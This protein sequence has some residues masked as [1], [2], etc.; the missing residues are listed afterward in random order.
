[1]KILVLGATGQVGRALT[2]ILGTSAIGLTRHHAD[3]S[4]PDSLPA[5]LAKT[6]ASNRIS[7]VI[8]AAAY[9]AVDLAETHEPE[10]M[11][12]NADSPGVIAGFCAAHN[13]PFVHYSTDYVFSGE[14]DR[15]WTERDPTAP[16]SAYGR[17]KL[18]GE[19]QVARAG[20]NHLILRTS[21]VYDAVGKNFL[22]TMLRLGQDR[23]VL[24]VVADQHGAP[25]YAPHLAA[26]T[27]A[28]LA[29]AQSLPVFAS[30]VYHLCGSGETSWNGFARAIFAEAEKIKMPLRVRIVEP[31][32]SSAY[33]MPAKRPLNSRLSMKKTQEILKLTLPRWEDGLS[34]CLSTL[35]PTKEL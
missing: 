10:A 8:N 33:P 16:L 22:T 34:D 2:S 5:V 28:A 25:T 7:A 29:Q 35:R 18:A 14:G 15:P 26:A 24:K 20:G 31:I 13:L 12:A 17:S 11:L 19:Q 3:F 27:L 1:M 9:T 21:W 32:P 23:E 6:I 30:G 4:K